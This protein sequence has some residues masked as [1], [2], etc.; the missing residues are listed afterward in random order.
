MPSLVGIANAG[1]RKVG[2]NTITS[3]TQGTVNA[4]FIN[5][6][7][8]EMRDSLLEM[9]Q[10]N[11]AVKRVKLA[12]L[13]ATPAIKF[14]YAYSLPAD[15][16]RAISVHDSNEGQVVV[17]HKIEDNKVL[18]SSDEVWMV[19]VSRVQDP[20]KMSPLFREALSNYIAVEAATSIAE[21][22]TLAEQAQSHFE[23]SLRRARSADSLSD[24]PDRMPTGSWLRDRTGR[25]AER[26]WSW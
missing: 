10:W 6:R 12:Q 2:A 4:N 7:F 9:H 24:L 14:D 26:K 1:L 11:F 19:Y 22:R 17:D 16:I 13:T 20:N 15:Y 21:S 23:K 18:C 3:F 8:D 5:D 25:N